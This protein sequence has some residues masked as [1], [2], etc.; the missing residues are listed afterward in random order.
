MSTQVVTGLFTNVAST[1][2]FIPLEN[3]I[4]EIRLK[5]LTRSGVAIGSVDGALTS[6]RIVEAFWCDYM[7]QGVAQIIENGTVSGILAPMNNGY[8]AINGFTVYNAANPPVY[9]I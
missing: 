6:T 8:A 1:P 3:Y 9:P 5:N 2:Y 7:K 4:S